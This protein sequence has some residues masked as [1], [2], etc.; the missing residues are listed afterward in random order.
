MS[1]RAKVSVTLLLGSVAFLAVALAVIPMHVAPANGSL[2]C[3]T[4]LHPD[5]RSEIAD[6]CPRARRGHLMAT[7][8][9]TG[10]LVAIAALPATAQRARRRLVG[11]LLVTFAVIWLFAATLALMLMGW[12]VEYSPPGETFNL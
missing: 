2:H 8:G 1:S 5:T 7:I 11:P 6:L 10:A 3:G 4:F 12:G 9:L